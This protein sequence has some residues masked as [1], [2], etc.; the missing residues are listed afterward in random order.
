MQGVITSSTAQLFMFAA[1]YT[2]IM[3]RKYTGNGHT[4]AASSTTVLCRDTIL[5]MDFAVYLEYGQQH[6]M[7]RP[8][9]LDEAHSPCRYNA[10]LT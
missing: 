3:A 2:I 8:A 10:G 5:I 7:S 1:Q 9:S 6:C 4:V